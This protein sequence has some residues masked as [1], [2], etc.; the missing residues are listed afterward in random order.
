MGE[1]DQRPFKKP[2]LGRRSV[3]WRGDSVVVVFELV[4][5]HQDGH[6][7]RILDLE[8][9]DVDAVAER[10]QQLAQEGAGAGLEVS[11]GRAAETVYRA[12]EAL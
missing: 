12:A 11:E 4:A 10:N 2:P 7:R 1:L 9:G 6:R 5:H 8:Q 3:A